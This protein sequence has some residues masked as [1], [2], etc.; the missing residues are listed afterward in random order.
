MQYTNEINQ[1]I[2]A[3]HCWEFITFFIHKS[4]SNNSIKIRSFLRRILDILL[5]YIGIYLC[6]LLMSW[7]E[8]NLRYSR[9]LTLVHE[10][11][12]LK[13]SINS[14]HYYNVIPISFDF[15]TFQE[16]TSVTWILAVIIHFDAENTTMAWKEN[17][18][19]GVKF[20][21]EHWRHTFNLKWE[22]RTRG[23][24]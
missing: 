11:T 20:L 6:Y 22:K 2:H 8:R 10:M 14:Y 7:T 23:I 24:Q 18:N 16:S 5:E 15:I 17:S 9:E 21:N 19:N 12:E 13:I 4:F 1:T 3:I